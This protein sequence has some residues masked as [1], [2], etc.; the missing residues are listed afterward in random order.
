MFGV[1]EHYKLSY[2]GHV[3]MSYN[4]KEVASDA[5]RIDTWFERRTNQPR[6]SGR[7]QTLEQQVD[8]LKKKVNIAIIYGGDKNATGAVI[9]PVPNTRSWKS[10]KV[11]AEDI[12]S[13]LTRLG[14]ASVHVLSDDMTL[15]DELKRR[16]IHFA[17]LNTGGVQGY[18]PMAHAA[19]MMEMYGLPYV[20]HDPLSTT[21][22]DN[23]HTFKRELAGM[24]LST[25][26]F[27]T[28]HMAR[29]MFDYDNNI[30]FRRE[31][32]DYN[33]PF[34]VKPVSG[35]ASLHVNVVDDA[36]DLG[37]VVAEVFHASQNQVLIERY[38][39]GREFCVAVSGLV[40]SQGRLLDILDQPFVFSPTERIL[41]ADEQIFTSMDIAPISTAR[42]KLLD[43]NIDAEVIGKLEYIARRV[44]S[45]LNLETIIRLDLRMD[46]EGEIHI[47]EANPKPDL[48]RPDG[49]K[50]SLVCTG[51]SEWGMDY[52]DL[53][54]S[55]ISDRVD[56]VFSQKRGT[57]HHISKLLDV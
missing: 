41:G 53:I 36:K 3:V 37:P 31:F 23:K 52:D 54:L 24:G 56:L 8:T 44:H 13:S 20:G 19:C 32:G 28:W 17:W 43:R 45:E 51:L 16:D 55:L 50:L 39:P 5:E 1:C 10:Y 49:D 40:R 33:G 7:A 35:R 30:N 14:F 47:L 34:I 57:V 9:N 18:N 4:V 25:S 26:P 12:A 2:R 38:L 11:V 29:G 48:K 22:L 42:A 6:R 15:G 27:M 46:E 21:V